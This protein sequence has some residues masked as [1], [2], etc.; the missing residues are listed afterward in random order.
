MG[1]GPARK[2]HPA[3]SWSGDTSTTSEEGQWAGVEFS[4]SI[5]NPC[6][7]EPQ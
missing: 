7:T 6:I 2:T 4:D 3:I 1:A 5:N